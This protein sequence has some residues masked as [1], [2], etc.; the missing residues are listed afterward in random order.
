MSLPTIPEALVSI[1]EEFDLLRSAVENTAWTLEALKDAI[2]EV[3]GDE[4]DEE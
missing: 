4:G 3:Y 2:Y 1:E